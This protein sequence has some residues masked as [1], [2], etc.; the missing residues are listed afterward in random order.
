M[1]AQIEPDFETARERYG[2]IL[3]QILAYADYCDDNGDPDSAKYRELE[4]TLHEITGKDMS[5]FDLWEWW[6]ADGAEN[7]AFNIALP[8]P[9]LVSDITKGE[10]RDIVERMSTFEPRETGDAF[11]DAFYYRPNFA[12]DGEYFTEFLKLN[13]KD[14]YDPRLFE[15]CE[16]SGEI[17]E[18]SAD[19]ITQILWG[20]RGEK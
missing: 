8:E 4:T 2:E 17:A 15:R 1:R 16:R 6:E 5:K 19:E 18:L 20:E 9:Q 11:L 3:K 12:T 10:L 14:T 13:F 7:L